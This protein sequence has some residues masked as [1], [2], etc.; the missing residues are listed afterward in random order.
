MPLLRHPQDIRALAD[1]GEF[2]RAA[3]LCQEMLD[4]DKLN[5]AVHF[6]HA[7][8]LEQ[9]G[10]HVEAEHALRRVIYLDRTF[11]LG[12]YYLGLLLQKQGRTEPATR[13]FRNVLQLLARTDDA[14]VL[15]DGDGISA[16][17]LRK[18]TQ[19]HL[20]VLEGTWAA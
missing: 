18:L 14:R 4:R 12:H 6:Y 3:A 9:T 19:M 17:E 2:D 8:V 16:G 1:R 20:A 15:D 10:K 13:S 11:I 5:P 7:L